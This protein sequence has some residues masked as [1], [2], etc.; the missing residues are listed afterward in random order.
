MPRVHAVRTSAA[1][2]TTSR[3]E[4]RARAQAERRPVIQPGRYAA[5]IS[6]RRGVDR[7]RAVA[8]QAA[9]EQFAK[10]WYRRTALRIF[11]DDAVLSANPDLWLSVQAALDRSDHL[12]LLA[13]PAAA[14]SDWIAREVAYWLEHKD[15]DDILVAVTSEE[16]TDEENRQI[17]GGG[18][19][20]VL[21]KWAWCVPAQLAER[22]GAG[23]E[24]RF[25]E[26][27]ELRPDRFT[28]RDPTFRR[29]L[30]ELAAPLHGHQTTEPL[31]DME[32][33][34]YVRTRRALR[35]GIAI[36][37]IMLLLAITG[38][39]VAFQ[40]RSSALRQ[41][42][43]A[44]SVQLASQ[45]ELL[46]PTNPRLAMLLSV[47]AAHVLDTPQSRSAMAHQLQRSAQT[48]AF[49]RD[50]PS[51]GRDVAFTLDGRRLLSSDP[52]G[53]VS[54]D[55]ATQSS[56]ALPG[57]VGTRALTGFSPSRRKAVANVDGD[58]DGDAEDRRVQAVDLASGAVSAPLA[59]SASP[60]AFSPDDRILATASTAADVASPVMLWDTD[61][62]T[63]LEMLPSEAGG[64]PWG[65]SPDGRI[66]AIDPGYYS[67]VADVILWDVA[68][69]RQL[70]ALTNG[71]DRGIFSLAFS[72]DGRTVATGGH[73]ARIVIWD[74]QT[75]A[76]LR[77][78]ATRGDVHDLAFT[79]DGGLL[80]SGDGN[81]EVVAWD[82]A[83]GEARHRFTGHVTAVRG[84][85]TVGGEV[86][87]VDEGGQVAVWD[88]G[89]RDWLLDGRLAGPAR[90]TSFRSDGTTL[91]L[92]DQEGV[93]MSMWRTDTRRL[94][95]IKPAGALSPDW[96]RIFVGGDTQADVPT[97]IT[98]ENAAGETLDIRLDALAGAGN[99]IAVSPDGSVLVTQ[100]SGRSGV[101]IWDVAKRLPDDT[102]DASD[103]TSVAFSADSRLV[104]LAETGSVVVYDVQRRAKVLEVP[105]NSV[106]GSRGLA[107]S[108]DQSRLAW[109]TIDSAGT[110]IGCSGC[111]V[112]VWSLEQNAEV[113]RLTGYDGVS[114]D[115]A[116]SPGG[117]MIA[118]SGDSAVVLWSTDGLVPIVDLPADRTEVLF[119]PM[120][121]VLATGGYGA[122]VDLWD[123]SPRSWKT[124]LCGIAGR[125]LTPAEWQLYV[126]ERPYEDVCAV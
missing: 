61:T 89:G 48:V 106:Y 75:G 109:T 124:K 108:P 5:F 57:E 18:A 81:S 91:A 29:K 38:A 102:F 126:G 87:S 117:D 8:L 31:Q 50:D 76:Q 36:L 101:L 3:F 73:D 64:S 122:V 69:R 41:L 15:P 56:A 86:V 35:G 104:A 28:L 32:D 26:L 39:G 94:V 100:N 23:N 46:A 43:V 20:H 83:S 9:L 13:C 88:L 95:D 12:L 120:G 60:A 66:L 99:P 54:W 10:P 30:L 97:T 45:S 2:R 65:F 21:N 82:P 53:S 114:G 4:G 78:W 27:Q 118:S 90:P 34:E 37:V 42:D 125:S 24:P 40:Q 123:V 14:T 112:I 80:V 119:D 98:E 71:H 107:F 19:D 47:A 55:P 6:Y 77:S 74:V 72:P 84:V 67:D 63:R 92:T 93:S 44:T 103:V 16:A 70:R 51:S 116:F 49:L 113:G 7:E 59:D 25:V 11:R 115:V 17:L 110:A 22:Y 1:S 79:D 111:A 33:R 62:G 96:S 52:S 105:E 68:G 121:T 85:D 58:V